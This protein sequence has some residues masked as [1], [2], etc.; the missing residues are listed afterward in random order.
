MVENKKGRYT[1]IAQTAEQDEI[2]EGIEEKKKTLDTQFLLIII[3]SFF[4][5]RLINSYL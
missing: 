1:H 2:L 4:S 5:M 3:I